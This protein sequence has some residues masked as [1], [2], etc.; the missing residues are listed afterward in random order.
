VESKAELPDIVYTWVK[1][2]DP[3]YRRL[4]EK[5]SGKPQHKN[6]ERYR[7]QFDLL[8]YSL[9]SLEQNFP[10]YRNL[11]LVTMR[12]QVPDWLNT[13]NPR[14][15]LVHHDEFFGD[16]AHLPTFNHNTIESYFHLLPGIGERFI[17][18]NDD[19]FF[20]KDVKLA[21]LF[22][23]A[24]PVI[25]GSLLG[26]TPRFRINDGAWLSLGFIEHCPVPVVLD[27]WMAMQAYAQDE[28][29]VTRQQKFRE[30]HHIR[31][32]RL[33]TWYMLKYRRSSCVLSPFWRTRKIARFLKVG[34]RLANELQN[35]K[36]LINRTPK[37]FCLNDDQGENASQKV[38]EA[39]QKYLATTY[40]IPSRYELYPSV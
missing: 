26:E 16:K 28:I 9:R 27:E 24:G 17:Y 7:D 15:R 6:P 23:E 20:G 25:Y 11:Y 40:P 38:I 32:D 36:N 37:F 14:L 29:L 8:R 39:Y 30:K 21:D 4:V 19:F 33:Y 13:R 2:E 3:D 31:M 35:I 18:M 10:H 12:P 5:Y 22:A 1:G 34:N